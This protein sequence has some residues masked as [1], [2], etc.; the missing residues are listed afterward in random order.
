M[1]FEVSRQVSPIED[2][3]GAHSEPNGLTLERDDDKYVH[4]NG[5]IMTGYDTVELGFL[6]CFARLAIVETLVPLIRFEL[7]LYMYT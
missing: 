1:P 4:D 7:N 6:Q 3:G 5:I 2:L